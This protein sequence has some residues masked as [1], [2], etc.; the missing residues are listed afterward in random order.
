MKSRKLIGCIAAALAATSLASQSVQAADVKITPLGSQEGEF[1]QLDR[2]LICGGGAGL[3]GLAPYLTAGMG[4]RFLALDA[5]SAHTLDSF[6]YERFVPETDTFG[7]F[8]GA[9]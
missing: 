8:T 3:K 2:A 7:V 4:V 6:V 1:C 9:N 5:A